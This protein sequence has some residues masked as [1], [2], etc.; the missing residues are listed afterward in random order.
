[1]SPVRRRRGPFS[2]ASSLQIA[3]LRALAQA[4]GA[5]ERSAGTPTQT[6]TAVVPAAGR[7]L[8]LPVHV[9]GEFAARAARRLSRRP[10]AEAIRARHAQLSER[11]P[12]TASLSI[13]L[14]GIHE[15]LACIRGILESRTAH[16]AGE[17][18]SRTEG[19]S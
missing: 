18:S 16:D 7:H 15:E 8:S 17:H 2:G 14:A 9:E 4:Y 1:M 12:D 6:R 19:Q 5:W 11:N 13:T 10:D 3:A